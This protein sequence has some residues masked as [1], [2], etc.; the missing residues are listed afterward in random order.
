MKLA[1]GVLDL[2]NFKSAL[3][4]P[5]DADVATPA[6]QTRVRRTLCLEV[7]LGSFKTHVCIFYL[8][9]ASSHLGRKSKTRLCLDPYSL[10]RLTPR[11]E[12][13]TLVSCLHLRFSVPVFAE[14]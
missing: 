4:R 12:F 7:T 13:M 8:C 6:S 9:L 3:L 10:H 11:L 1:F 2:E 14:F 5:L